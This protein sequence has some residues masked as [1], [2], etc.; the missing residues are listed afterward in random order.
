MSTTAT[1]LMDAAQQTADLI[2]RLR[3]N[4]NPGYG[5]SGD[6]GRGIDFHYAVEYLRDAELR[7]RASAEANQVKD[8]R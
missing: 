5:Y 2:A 3:A 8:E 1:L 7:L 4:A 6:G